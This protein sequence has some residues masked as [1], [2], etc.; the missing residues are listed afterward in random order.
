MA[1]TATTEPTDPTEQ[2][3]RALLPQ[4]PAEL[5]ERVHKG[6]QIW[7]A[8]ELLTEFDVIGFQAPFVVVRRKADQVTGTL[9]FTHNPRYYFG[10][11]AAE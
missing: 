8:K 5:R 4:M 10:W 3:R 9:M 7:T 2:A 6:E 1:M 11:E